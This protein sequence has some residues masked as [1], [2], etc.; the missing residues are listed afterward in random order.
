VAARDVPDGTGATASFVLSLSTG[1][2]CSPEPVVVTANQERDPEDPFLITIREPSIGICEGDRCY[3]C[4][5]IDSYSTEI[6]VRDLVLAGTY[7]VC[8][9]GDA[10]CTV[11]VTA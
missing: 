5:C 9:E 2:C 11:D 3:P 8:V 1:M 6:F 7:T 4:A 10:C